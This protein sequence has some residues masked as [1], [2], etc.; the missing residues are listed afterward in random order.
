MVGMVIGKNEMLHKVSLERKSIPN[1][2]E[3]HIVPPIS[4]TKI[5]NGVDWPGEQNKRKLK[6]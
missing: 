2:A 4:A 6:L 1:S 3:F 5:E